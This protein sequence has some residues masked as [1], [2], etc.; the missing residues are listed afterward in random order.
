MPETEIP[1]L[2]EWK[3]QSNGG[4]FASRSDDAILTRIDTLVGAYN[5]REKSAKEWMDVFDRH[6]ILFELY[7][8]LDS[9]LKEAD[10][11]RN[12]ATI[13]KRRPGVQKLYE[14]VVF[15]LCAYYSVTPNVL[16]RE[17]EEHF[18]KEMVEH[19]KKTDAK[20]AKGDLKK[21]QDDID[22]YMAAQSKG[23]WKGTF[24]DPVFETLQP[25][26]KDRVETEQYRIFFRNGLAFQSPWWDKSARNPAPVRLDTKT[27]YKKE[28]LSN[29][30]RAGY[31]LSMSRDLYV[32]QHFV[33]RDA[34]FYHSS[35]LKGEK[36]Q[37]AGELRCIAGQITMVNNYSGHYQP[38]GD[39]LVSL[40]EHLA[41]N[42]VNMS[43]MSCLV[44][45]DD[46]NDKN[47]SIVDCY[48]AADFLK[49]KGKM[50]DGDK[51]DK[52]DKFIVDSLK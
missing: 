33:N 12:D 27:Q 21:L 17:L 35:Y 20:W 31:A 38:K 48:K 24:K 42:K 45:R 49:K 26:Y 14:A 2:A 15:I 29:E 32:A 4:L 5:A 9:W 8:C 40:L 50:A 28:T 52:T 3:E 34:A 1:T 22:K 6:Y 39:S 25:I 19:G 13:K 51:L 36:V 23:E 11:D 47:A 10:R 30:G 16:P 37:C 41:A 44:M 43:K 46:P 7:W 18:G